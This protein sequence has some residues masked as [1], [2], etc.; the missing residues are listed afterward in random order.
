V[1]EAGAQGILKRCRG[2]QIHRAARRNWFFRH[3]DP[4]PMR[5]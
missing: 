5:G 1:H 2:K 3:F 4:Q